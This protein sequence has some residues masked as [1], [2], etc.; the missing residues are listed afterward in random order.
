[1]S[2]MSFTMY[3]ADCV[4]NAANCLYPHKVA[5]TDAASFKA[6]VAKDYVFSAFKDSYRSGENFQCADALGV[7]CDNDHSDDPADWVTPEDVAAVFKDVGFVIHYSRHHNLQKGKRSPRPGFHIIFAID[8]ETDKVKYAAMK[9]T[10]RQI[11]PYID[12]QALDASRFF[13]G[14]TDPAVEFHDG[15]INLTQFLWDWESNEEMS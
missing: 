6:A 12:K 9:D 10:V 14:T 11:F 4:G 13:F 2:T 1:M 3:H 7:D 5:V 15:S 8:D